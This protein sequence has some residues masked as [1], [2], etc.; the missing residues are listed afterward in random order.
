MIVSRDE[1]T[2]STYNMYMGKCVKP[3][4]LTFIVAHDEFFGS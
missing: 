4:N 3:G 1:N 2:D